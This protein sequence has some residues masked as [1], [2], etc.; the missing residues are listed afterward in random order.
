MI[1]RKLL[2]LALVIL[3]ALP[4]IK[5]SSDEDE[6]EDEILQLTEQSS[7]NSYLPVVYQ[8]FVPIAYSEKKGVANTYGRC[9]IVLEVGGQIQYGWSTRPKS[10]EGIENVPMIWGWKQFV[11]VMAGSELGG[12]SNYLLG[13]NEPDLGGQAGLHPYEAAV[14]WRQ[15]EHKFNDK[16]LI[17]P[18]PSHLHPSWLEEFREAYIDIYNEPPRLDGLAAHCYAD[19]GFCKGTVRRYINWC[20]EWEGC[21]EVWV[22][23]FAWW[24]D[25]WQEEM[26][27]FIDW[28]EQ[29]PLIK[30]YFWFA[31]LVK[32]EEW[33]GSGFKP[34]SLSDK[35]GNLTDKGQFYRSIGD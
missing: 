27:E 18:V 6:D 30:H 22:T 16:L 20:H 7:Y 8:N 5:C 23:E 31:S 10:C 28:M 14:M 3:L 21:E 12:N 33:W 19:A 17:S 34:A 2:V 1:K 35:D 9:D 25:D 13:F 24:E 29:E 11:A 32:G 15:I 26:E 4:L